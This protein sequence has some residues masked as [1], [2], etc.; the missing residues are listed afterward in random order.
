MTSYVVGRLQLGNKEAFKCGLEE[1]DVVCGLCLDC[2][3]TDY[4]FGIDDQDSRAARVR[5]HVSSFS[6]MR[7]PAYISARSLLDHNDPGMAFPTACRANRRR[8]IC[9][10]TSLL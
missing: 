10:E 5:V 7:T 1:T 9:R 2:E 6:H 8:L 3:H 4:G